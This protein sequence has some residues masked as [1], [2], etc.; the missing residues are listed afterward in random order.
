MSKRSFFISAAAAAAAT[1]T[2][3]Q[4]PQQQQPSSSQERRRG[5]LHESNTTTTATGK[6]VT[7]TGAGSSSYYPLQQQQR[8]QHQQHE[9]KQ[10]EEAP[11]TIPRS[12]TN[13]RRRSAHNMK[14]TNVATQYNHSTITNPIQ[15]FD[16]DSDPISYKLP[17]NYHRRR[18]HSIENGSDKYT[19][20]RFPSSSTVPPTTTMTTVA[21]TINSRNRNGE[22]KKQDDVRDSIK[23]KSS[24]IVAT[25]TD[26]GNNRQS[27]MDNNNKN[28]HHQHHSSMVTERIRMLTGSHE[29]TTSDSINTKHIV[30]LT[31]TQS[32]HDQQQ[33][34]LQSDTMNANDNRIAKASAVNR[35]DTHQ[36]FDEIDSIVLNASK[37]SSKCVNAQVDKHD[38]VTSSKRLL[39]GFPSLFKNS[40]NIV[41]QELTRINLS[42]ASSS[43]SSSKESKTSLQSHQTPPWVQDKNGVILSPITRSRGP[44]NA[45]SNWKEQV[46]RQQT[47]LQCLDSVSVASDYISSAS[48]TVESWNLVLPTVSKDKDDMLNTS[49]ESPRPYLPA[50]LH[51]NVSSSMLYRSSHASDGADLFDTDTDVHSIVESDNDVM[52]VAE[53]EAAFQPMVMKSSNPSPP[54]VDDDPNFSSKSF[55]SSSSL[56]LGSPFATNT[57]FP[58]FESKRV[59][60]LHKIDECSDHVWKEMVEVNKTYWN[61]ENIDNDNPPKG[62]S[63]VCYWKVPSPLSFGYKV[64]LDDPAYRH[65]QKAGHLWQSLVS[66]HIRFP[67]SWYEGARSPPLGCP[68]SPLTSPLSS[69]TLPQWQYC[70][71]Y[72]IYCHPVLNCLVRGRSSA[73]RVLLH[74]IIKDGNTCEPVSDIAI[75]CFHPNA[76]KVRPGTDAN[77][78]Q[79]SRRDIWIAIRNRLTAQCDTSKNVGQSVKPKNGFLSP[80]ESLL[81]TEESPLYGVGYE[82]DSSSNSPLHQSPTSTVIALPTTRGPYFKS[83]LGGLITD[84]TSGNVLFKPPRVS[85]ENVRAIFGDEPPL[86]TIFVPENELYECLMGW[87]TPTKPAAAAADAADNPSWTPPPLALLQEYV[88]S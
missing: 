23:T 82:F 25:A 68:P 41:Q 60:S 3:Q 65:A 42:H 22:E 85:N 62:L 36:S 74:I 66:Q 81:V 47:P 58:Q 48:S 75:G 51:S 17:Q 2:T 33:K 10:L 4:Q 26:V 88:F 53:S 29:V 27:G 6:P 63:A 18:D 39:H 52:T 14:V 19:G 76:R 67:T 24:R 54:I 61:K 11:N 57:K 28:N 55:S 30:P 71:R 37:I 50:A 35:V 8:Q 31:R 12:S 38:V 1:T 70:G 13:S 80:L 49:V 83:P 15:F 21:S 72:P 43:S 32:H 46:S 73:G 86:E 7:T 40:H 78:S 79:E 45:D 20:N 16:E 5:W 84:A 64:L 56:L 69:V 34:Q 77:P 9:P 59:D 44:N 87:N